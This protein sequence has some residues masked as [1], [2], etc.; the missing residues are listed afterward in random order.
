MIADF[1]YFAP[2]T[3]KEAVK[4]LTRYEDSKIIAGGQSLLVVLKQ[5]F[6][7]PGYLIDIKNMPGLDYIKSDTKGLKIGALATHGAIEKSPVIKEK[8]P[9]LSEMEN[10]V[11]TIQTR[12]WGTIGGNLS[13]GDPAGDPA[14]VFIVLN[15]KLKITGPDG[16]RTIEM[17]EFSKDYLE[18]SL[19]HNERLTEIQVPV[20]PAHTGVAHRKLMVMKGDMGTVGCAVA[21]TLEKGNTCKNARIALSNAASVPLR[22]KAA[23]NLLIGKVINDDLLALAAEAA[24]AES[25]P[26]ADV[27]G[28][29]EYRKEM[30][31]VFVKRV[32]A[33]ALERAMKEN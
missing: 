32:G 17:E 31:K 13:H 26:S 1:E 21:I 7:T 23:E 25:D 12:N 11:A 24:A 29:A 6:I 15:A 10:N 18:T 4:L 27:H 33:L 20:I 2:K 28:S 8:F 19:A 9:V 14:V 30:V 22:A 5:K 16:N 3:V